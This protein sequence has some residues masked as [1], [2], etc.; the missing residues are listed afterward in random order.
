M[1]AEV[2]TTP[3]DDLAISYKGTSGFSYYGKV[4]SSPHFR[5]VDFERVMSLPYETWETN[6]RHQSKIARQTFARPT[7]KEG[8]SGGAPNTPQSGGGGSG[9]LPAG[10]HFGGH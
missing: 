4:R 6:K 1:F 7:A 2:L 5:A 8:N 9:S 3:G 10:V